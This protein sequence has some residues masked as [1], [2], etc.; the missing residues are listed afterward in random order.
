VDVLKKLIHGTILGG[1]VIEETKDLLF[2]FDL[3]IVF[4]QLRMPPLYLAYVPLNL[5]VLLNDL[6]VNILHKLLT[7][8]ILVIVNLSCLL[9]LLSF[10][11]LNI[12][13]HVI[14]LNVNILKFIYAFGTL[15]FGKYGG[16]ISTESLGSNLEPTGSQLERLVHWPIG[17]TLLDRLHFAK[18]KL[19]GGTDGVAIANAQRA[20]VVLECRH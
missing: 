4:L 11:C 18:C 16:I 13:W 20:V 5:F 17:F 9:L 12:L 7:P 6:L 3:S 10:R 1:L 2:I 14:E 19:R 8:H 15:T